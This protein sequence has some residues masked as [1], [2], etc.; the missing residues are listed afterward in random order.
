MLAY[1]CLQ[2][3]GPSMLPA[4]LA[5][6]LHNGAIIAHLLGRQADAMRPRPDGPRGLDLYAW[7][8]TPLLYGQFM[9]Y[10]L[11]RA[12]IV[13]RESAILGLLGVHTWA[14]TWRTASR[15]CDSIARRR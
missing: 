10:A 13:F 2:I 12:E 3:L 8:M 5:L 1:L 4:I 6:A 11:Y 14:S 15:S 9:A 7:E